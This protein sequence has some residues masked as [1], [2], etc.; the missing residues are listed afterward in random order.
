MKSIL[1]TLILFIQITI[2]LTAQSLE[3]RINEIATEFDLMGSAVVVFCDSDSLHYYFTGK[4]D[5]ARNIDIAQN[6]KLEL[7]ASQNPSQLSQSCSQLN[8]TFLILTQTQETSQ[9]TAFET[10]TI[11]TRVSQ[12][13]CYSHTN[14]QQLMDQP[15]ITS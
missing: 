2:T 1:L 15:T 8:K 10:Q 7:P 11:Q 3:S 14:R 12:P 4:S 13:E 9:N 5:L 6:T